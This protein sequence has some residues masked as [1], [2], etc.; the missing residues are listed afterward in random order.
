MPAMRLNTLRLL[1]ELHNPNI[2]FQEL[3]NIVKQDVSLSYKLLRLINSAY[4][5]RPVK[6]QSIRQALTLLGIKKVQAWVSLLFLSKIEEK[7]HELMHTAMVRAHMCEL[8]AQKQKQKQKDTETDFTVGLF[9][10]LDSL[11]DL[12][13]AE[14]LSSLSFSDEINTALLQHQ[15]RLGEEL[16]CVLAY[17][18]GDWDKVMDYS[19]NKPSD[20]RDA[21]LEAL[22]WARLVNAEM[23]Y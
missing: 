2:E 21:Y 12:P 6:V 4:Y 9:S 8:L 16:D 5:T 18:K 14:V 13:L 15:G 20:I 1:A 7:P 22:K 10:V 17:E 19:H 11:L 23:G 3:E